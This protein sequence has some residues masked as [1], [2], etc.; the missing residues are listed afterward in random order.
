MFANSERITISIDPF[1]GRN[2]SYCFVE[3]ATKEQAELA[4]RELNGID[5]LGRPVKIK[6]GVSKS[7]TPR[8]GPA[9]GWNDFRTNRDPGNEPPRAFQRWERTDASTHWEPPEGIRLFVGGLP[10]MPDHSALEVEIHR[11][12]QGFAMYV[13]LQA[14]SSCVN[15]TFTA[16]PSASSSV[17]IPRRLNYPA[18]ITSA[19]WI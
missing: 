14:F 7:S 1:T 2:P 10:R 5:M 15:E 4:M 6:P 18:I 8:R 9:Q 3:L 11:L 13:P 12:F 19:L 17:L 16:R